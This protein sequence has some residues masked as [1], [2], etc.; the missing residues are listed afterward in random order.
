MRVRTSALVTLAAAAVALGVAVPALAMSGSQD[1]AKGLA[2]A[3]GSGQSVV[4]WNRQ[5]ITVLG[6]PNSVFASSE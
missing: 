1:P 6:T 4:D 2:D 3:P 5:L